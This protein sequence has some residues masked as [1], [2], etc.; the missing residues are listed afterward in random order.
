M[1]LKMSSAKWRPFGL[2][3]NELTHATTSAEDV[4][5]T[6][7]IGNTKPT[8]RMNHAV[9]LLDESDTLVIWSIQI[10]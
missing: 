1:H 6:Y 10:K 4:Q 5:Q 7:I 3:L 9:N 8:R 2:G